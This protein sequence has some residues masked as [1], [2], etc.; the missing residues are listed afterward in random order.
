MELSA[1][2]G[3][4]E[5]AVGA[6]AARSAGVGWSSGATDAEVDSAAAGTGEIAGSGAGLG[7]GAEAV[8]GVAGA[9][10]GDGAEAVTGVTGRLAAAG[11]DTLPQTSAIRYPEVDLPGLARAAEIVFLSSEPYP[12]RAQDLRQLTERLPGI[13][14]ALIDGE[15]VSWYGSRAIRG[16][17]YL[18]ELR[19]SLDES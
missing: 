7:G 13:R 5:G 15:M 10:R 11:W 1:T 9:S 2:D 16:L 12:F 19:A 18:R 17:A 3:A 14:A 6:T 4:P 8:A